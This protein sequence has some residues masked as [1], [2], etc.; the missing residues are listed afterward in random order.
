[1]A[2]HPRVTETVL[3]LICAGAAAMVRPWRLLGHGSRY[4][5]LLPLLATFICISLLWWWPG[6]RFS[7]LFGLV[8][9]NLAL[10]MLGWPLAVLT[11]C[12]SGVFGLVIGYGWN[13]V[14][15]GIAWQGLLPATLAL[16]LGYV[17]RVGLGPQPLAYLFGRGFWIP[18]ASTSIT[19]WMADTFLQRFG[20]LGTHAPAA[21]FLTCLIDAMLTL[22][23]LCLLVLHKPEC[24]ATWSDSLYLSKQG[25]GSRLRRLGF[26]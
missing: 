12:A 18:L 1:V 26:D 22:G 14:A 3:L 7:P 6:T 4:S 21:I 2:E 25:E 10:L 16:A 9:A 8:G 5:L 15:A 24:L 19:A 17:W 20:W 11:F 23:V 13:A